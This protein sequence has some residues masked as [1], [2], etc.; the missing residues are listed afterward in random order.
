MVCTM[1]KYISKQHMCRHIPREKARVVHLHHL[2]YSKQVHLWYRCAF[3]DWS[4]GKFYANLLK[5]L[6]KFK[7]IYS[8]YEHLN[9]LYTHILDF[10]I[11]ES[12]II[13]GEI[14]ILG[15]VEMFSHSINFNKIVSINLFNLKS[16]WY[17]IYVIIFNF[18]KFY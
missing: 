13:L 1:W 5:V 8:L 17:K 18:T 4:D 11:N 15:S 9:F 14:K 2:L 10:I 6:I 12:L 3:I 7:H 16:H